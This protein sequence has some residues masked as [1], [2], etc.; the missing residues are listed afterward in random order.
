MSGFLIWGPD[1][2]LRVLKG[3]GLE[4]GNLFGEFCIKQTPPEIEFLVMDV[5]CFLI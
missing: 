1:V 5:F 3:A 4:G 2:E